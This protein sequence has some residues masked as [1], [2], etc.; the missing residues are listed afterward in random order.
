MEK[1]YIDILKSEI[2]NHFT[3]ANLDKEKL[4]EVMLA[5]IGNHDPEIRDGL[6]YRNLAHLLHD[7]HFDA[8]RLQE[9]TGQLL[10]D[11]YLLKGIDDDARLDVLTRSFTAL[12]L[13]ILNFVHTRDHIYTEEFAKQAIKTMLEY[14]RKEKVLDGHDIKYGWL[15][16][17]A[18]SADMFSLMV[19]MKEVTR[20]DLE[21]LFDA[22]AEKFLVSHYNYISDEDE[23]MVN[24]LKKA[25]DR[26]MLSEDYLLNWVKRIS[27]AKTPETYPEFYHFKNNRKNLLR[28]LYFRIIGDELRNELKSALLEAIHSLEKGR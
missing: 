5:N 19:P 26:D 7:K 2:E 6:V 8:K 4:L 12:Q 9:I 17:I 1:E 13:A 22:V 18:H 21:N 11:K 16:A 10:G 20:E 28:S 15:H 24:A 3:F 14:F 25:I 23:R 27:E